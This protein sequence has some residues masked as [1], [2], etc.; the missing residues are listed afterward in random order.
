MV[1][2]NIFSAL[3]DTVFTW[4]YVIVFQEDDENMV[5][6]ALFAAIE[7]GNL[8]GLQEL[9]DN[10]QN[11]DI[12]HANKVTHIYTTNTIISHQCCS[13]AVRASFT[14]AQH[15]NNIGQICS[16]TGCTIYNLMSQQMCYW[17]TGFFLL[18]CHK[19][20]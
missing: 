7:D 11:L 9:V 5:A 8:A 2:T 14:W 10:A 20:V 3:R 4:Y 18:I 17:H 6:S 19:Y 16:I 13:N 1:Y 15:W 12:N